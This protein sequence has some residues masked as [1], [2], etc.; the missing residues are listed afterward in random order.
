MAQHHYNVRTSATRYRCGDNRTKVKAFVTSAWYHWRHVSP[1]L[2]PYPISGFARGRRTLLADIVG[3]NNGQE[4]SPLVQ[5]KSLPDVTVVLLVNCD[6]FV[7][8]MTKTRENVQHSCYQL[9][10]AA[11]QSTYKSTYSL[12]A[13]LVQFFIRHIK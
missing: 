5:E 4:G 12:M 2:G 13:N 3:V 6:R 8:R 11:N 7:L 10:P 1:Y 9:G